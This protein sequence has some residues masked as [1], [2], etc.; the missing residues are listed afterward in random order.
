MDDFCRRALA[1]PPLS[2]ETER[3]LARR[4]AEGD[5]AAR[6]ELVVA[7]LR[8]VVLRALM[9]GA[10]DDRLADAVQAGTVGL[11]RAIDRFDPERGVRLAT[12]AW[13][14]IG[15]E[16]L[17]ELRVPPTDELV[18]AVAS[19]FD[20]DPTSWLDGLADEQAAVLRLRLGLDPGTGPLSRRAV[21]ERLGIGVA[22]VR[23][24]EAEAMRHL[25]GAV[26]RVGGRAPAPPEPIL[27]SSIGRAADC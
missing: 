16:V 3:G 26:A 1:H 14:W 15:G 11:I 2:R 22:V 21:G 4:A 10:R 18:E 5:S 23:R 17:A 6:D 25:R 12:Y 24:V 9:L 27:Y 7:T 8:S 20:D 19:P 13:S